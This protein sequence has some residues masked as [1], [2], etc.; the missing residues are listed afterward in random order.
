M[1]DRQVGLHNLKSG[2][3]VDTAPIKNQCSRDYFYTKNPAFEQSFTELEGHHG[4]LIDKIIGTETAPGAADRATL[5][6]CIMF[7]EGRTATAAERV[8]ELTNQVGK[9]MLRQYLE[10]VGNDELLTHLPKLEITLPDAVM[11]A[12][13]QHLILWPLIDDLDCTVVLNRTKED[14]LTSDHPVATCNSLPLTSPSAGQMGFSS[15]GLII[16]FPLSPKVL[17]CLTDPE[18]Y[19]VTK[20]ASGAVL[21]T[22]QREIVE[23]NL[24]QCF[25]AFENL[26]F[27]DSSRAQQT[28]DAFKKRANDLRAKP[29]KLT[30][31]S[32]KV[33]AGRE[34]LLIG[35]T[36]Q[37][38]RLKLPASI[39][40][41]HAAKKGEYARGDARVR[42]HERVNVV[43][44]EFDQLRRRREEA[45][46]KAKAA[47]A[48][49]G[50]TT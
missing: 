24:V 7:Q 39:V 26:Y 38:R 13:W 19:K 34:H 49:G 42:D 2:R 9:S 44:A 32:A 22:D 15:R 35:A 31:A 47:S 40:V 48:V 21:I 23:M 8:N 41:R 43:R 3:T 11:E 36:R 17:V 50:T 5:S 46:R 12:I 33:G 14:F 16:L 27:A 30:E 18:V 29:L 4:A 10:R 1:S 28:L 37:S 6:T 25:N 45:T 20:N